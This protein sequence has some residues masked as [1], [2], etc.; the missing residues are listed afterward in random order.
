MLYRP[1]QSGRARSSRHGPATSPPWARPAR[2]R[3]RT[4][5]S[6][7]LHGRAARRSV[8]CSDHRSTG[9]SIA[10][11]RP[12]LLG[13]RSGSKMRARSGAKRGASKKA[14]R[15]AKTVAPTIHGRGQGRLDLVLDFVSFVAKSMPLSLLL[16]EAPLRIA[17]IVGAD[18]ASLYLLEG[19][20]DELVLRG[21]V[22]F[23]LDVRGNVRLSVGEGITGMAVECLRPISVIQAPE[24]KA[25]RAF[26][27]LQEDRFPVF[28]AVPILGHQRALGALVVQRA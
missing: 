22:G 16:D 11:H 15:K 14:A 4:S 5:S 9:R 24:H 12:P 21:N 26:P 13:Y 10:A 2:A 7:W 6:R 19:E 20:G 27:E 28:L 8:R 23:P 25:F 17:A 3:S 1:A 18:V